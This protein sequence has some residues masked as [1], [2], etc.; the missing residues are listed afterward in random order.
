M[1]LHPRSSV[2]VRTTSQGDTSGTFASE[3]DRLARE[4]RRHLN[5]APVD[6]EAS[7][8]PDFTSRL[9]EELDEKFN[10]GLRMVR[11]EMEQRM[12]DAQKKW[13]KERDHLNRKITKLI[14]TTDTGRVYA[15]IQK[16]E[17]ELADVSD[18]VDAMVED[19]DV[20]LS[21]VMR[22]KSECGE[23]RTYLR[24]LKCLAGNNESPKDQ[25]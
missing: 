15:E 9:E 5:S 14:Q 20:R 16:T 23:L 21:E 22:K 12:E 17:A 6:A 24:G 25:P 3:V 13:G 1:Q 19:A 10:A 11:Q 2:V 18:K 8:R 4:F 7:L